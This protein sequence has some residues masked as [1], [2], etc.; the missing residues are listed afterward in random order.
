MGTKTFEFKITLDEDEFLQVG[1]HIFTTHESL[2]KEEPTINFIHPKCLK[3][4]KEF[5]GRLNMKVVKE[6]RL[7]SRAL[8]QSC[9]FR[10]SWDDHKIIEELIAGREHSISWY[11]ENCQRAPSYVL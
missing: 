3:I 1:N 9:S 6:W 2:K 10:S 8:D 7:L 11:V 5:E 4:L